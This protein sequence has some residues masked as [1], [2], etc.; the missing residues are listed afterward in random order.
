MNAPTGT[1]IHRYTPAALGGDGLRAL[2]G[3]G[4]SLFVL[5]VVGVHG[6][7]FTLFLALTAL[8]A[9]YGLQVAERALTRVELDPTRIRA[10][11]PRRRELAWRELNAVKLSY[12]RARRRG[13]EGWMQLKLAGPGGA[14][15][16]DSHIDGFDAIARAALAAAI[17]NRLA[18]SE[19][20]Q[21]NFGALGLD[22]R[23]W[24]SP[25]SWGA[26]PTGT[27]ST[28]EGGRA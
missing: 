20:T 16:L 7:V 15:A 19:A 8:F 28:G 3:L 27:A 11:G 2:A 12:F 5:L 25:R 24:G 17:A 22:Q 21:T 18:L 6:L 14:L 9:A 13:R 1:S 4:M 26:P 10:H 23:G